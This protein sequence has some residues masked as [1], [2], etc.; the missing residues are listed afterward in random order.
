MPG[1][2]AQRVRTVG[3]ADHTPNHR[4]GHF[5]DFSSDH[6]AGVHFLLADGAVRRIADTIDEE[7]YKALC[8]RMGAEPVSQ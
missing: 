2:K 1:T 3:I 4:D 7:T 5:D 6:P 8:T